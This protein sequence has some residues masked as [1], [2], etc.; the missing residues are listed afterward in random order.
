MEESFHTALV[1]IFCAYLEPFFFLFH[2]IEA[3]KQNKHQ[4][5]NVPS[6]PPKVWTQSWF[7]GD[8]EYTSVLN[9]VNIEIGN[10]VVANLAFLSCSLGT[11]CDTKKPV[12]N[13]NLGQQNLLIEVFQF[14]HPLPET[15]TKIH[16]WDWRK[17]LGFFFCKTYTSSVQY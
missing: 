16:S 6:C 3:N 17:F 15:T 7:S 4:S 12:F 13:G 1:N 8:F 10:W 9:H 2:F 5:A 14:I 11:V